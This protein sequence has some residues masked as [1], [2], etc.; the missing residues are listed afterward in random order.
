MQDELKTARHEISVLQRLN[1]E[2][3]KR[4]EAT[5]REKL[6]MEGKYQALREK[7]EFE[8][9]VGVFSESSALLYR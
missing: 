2:L 9:Q 6:N 7:I 8:K 4:A 3:E 1:T 5:L